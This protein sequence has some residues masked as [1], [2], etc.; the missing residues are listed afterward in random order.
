MCWPENPAPELCEAWKAAPAISWT[1]A[2][3]HAA[4]AS[5]IK[6]AL[7]KCSAFPSSVPPLWKCLSVRTYHLDAEE[8]ILSYEETPYQCTYHIWH[9][10]EMGNPFTD[11]ARLCTAQWGLKGNTWHLVAD[12]YSLAIFASTP[13]IVGLFMTKSNFERFYQV[14]NL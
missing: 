1:R 14:D 12:P 7:T 13:K 2:L 5:Y 4:P 3:R 9:E 6:P 10:G 11:F 8:N